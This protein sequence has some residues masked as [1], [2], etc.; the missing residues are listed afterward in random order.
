MLRTSCIYANTFLLVPTDCSR[1]TFDVGA[2]EEREFI[3]KAEV[4]LDISYSVDVQIELWL[5]ANTRAATE[6]SRPSTVV[7][8]SERV[9]FQI[10]KFLA[11]L[12]DSDNFTGDLHFDL[13]AWKT[14]ANGQSNKL[15]CSSELE[16]RKDTPSLV[17]YSYDTKEE[18]LET[19]QKKLLD[20]SYTYSPNRVPYF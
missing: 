19:I 8:S 5:N 15:S 11:D 14:D 10:G 20:S 12:V 1:L 18:L 9:V 2:I 4:Y 13:L 17:V 16:I 6:L 7:A 3:F